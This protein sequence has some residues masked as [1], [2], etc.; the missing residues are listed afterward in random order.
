MFEDEPRV[1]E[2]LTRLDNVVLAPHVGSAT[3]ATR[4]A[5]GRLMLDNPAAQLA[6]KPL[7]TPAI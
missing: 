7:P 3:H 6:S 1:P 4:L 5:M 2:A